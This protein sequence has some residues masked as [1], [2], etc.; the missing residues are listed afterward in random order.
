MSLFCSQQSELRDKHSLKC[1]FCTSCCFMALL[2]DVWFMDGAGGVI[3]TQELV[4]ISGL[5]SGLQNQNLH[6]DKFPGDSCA[7]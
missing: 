6:F 4:R 1:G 7:C 5:T 2:L 3:I